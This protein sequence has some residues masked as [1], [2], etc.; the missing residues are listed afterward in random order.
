MLGRGSRITK[1]KK[2]ADCVAVILT[3]ALLLAGKTPILAVESDRDNSIRSVRVSDSEIAVSTLVIGSYLIDLNGL[4]DHIYE[5]AQESAGEFSQNRMY[6]KSELS[7]G[8]W[9]E[10]TDA[11]SIRDITDAGTP[12]SAGVIEALAF[13]HRVA[14]NGTVT[15]LRVQAAVNEFDIPDP[16]DLMNLEELLPVKTH[17]Q[18]LQSKETRTESDEKY[19]EIMEIFYGLSIEDDTTRDC[20]ASLDALNPYKLDVIA[21][22]KPSSWAEAVTTVMEGEDARRR[23]QSLHTLDIYLDELL[24][25]ASGQDQEGLSREEMEAFYASL[26]E[27]YSEHMT[28]IIVGK[29]DNDVSSDDSNINE[30]DSTDGAKK[31]DKNWLT[32]WRSMRENYLKF[33]AESGTYR[34][35]VLDESFLMD[36]DMI[37][38]IGEAKSNVKTSIGK[39]SGKLLTEGTAASAQAIFQYSKELINCARAGDA[40]GCDAAAT[41]LVNLLNILGDVIEDSDSERDTLAQELTE[42]ALSVW[43]GILSGGAGEAYR[44]AEGEGAGPPA[45]TAFL[46]Q[47]ETDADS[48]R[49]EYQTMLSEMW[50]RMSNSLAQID[51]GE[52]IN[53]IGQL[54]ALPPGDAA[55]SKL[56]GSVARHREWLKKSLA[57]L[58]AAS[59]D[60]TALD[61]LLEEQ[62]DLERQ[63][64]NALDANDLAEAKRLAAE[65][66]AGQHDIDD[67]RQALYQTLTDPDSSQADKARAAAGMTEGSTGKLIDELADNITSGIWDDTEGNALTYDMAALSELAQCDP[68]AALAAV[69]EIQDALDG[70]ADTDAGLTEEVSAQLSDIERQISDAGGSGR[71]LTKEQLNSLLADYF[72]GTSEVSDR[73]KAGALIAL[74]RYAEDAH[75]RTAA[76]MA[77]S[78]ANRFA[79]EGSPYL[80]E[81]YD[82]A[83]EPYVSLQS[84]GRI[85][86]YRY[87]FDDA[88]H[89]VTLQKATEYYIFTAGDPL[90]AFMESAEGRLSAGPVMKNTLYLNSDDGNLLFGCKGYYVPG[91]AYAAARTKAMEPVIED[92]YNMLMRGG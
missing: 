24:K 30:N 79:A 78:V 77:V 14:A 49:L 73:D 50:K 91:C 35:V 29:D 89:I 88:H 52:R 66:E 53:S 90:Y 39:Y 85:L 69:S 84:I 70:A 9:F 72:D 37:S 51:A 44:Q 13:T 36:S 63:R 22:E 46:S 5:I 68:S 16:Y 40:P 42:R 57:E 74:S 45:L 64:L 48:A 47:R 31:K 33:L 23:V 61:R 80:Y 41:K 15:D 3:T 18:F 32:K 26:G 58:I 54:E 59:A 27:Q 67:L 43:Q 81:K 19:L 1:R 82:R 21:R 20:D 83:A 28:D 65:M 71:T 12:V 4:G 17:Y 38:A 6:Y 92:I 8:Q 11:V 55:Q 60:S 86:G 10:I 56:L 62:S 75:N 87:L 76:F 25:K 34:S 7:G 2:G